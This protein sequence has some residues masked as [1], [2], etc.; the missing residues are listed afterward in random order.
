MCI[1]LE[2][3]KNAVEEIKKDNSWINDSHTKSEYDGVCSGLNR[4]IT[5]FER[6][7]DNSEKFTIDIYEYVDWD[8]ENQNKAYFNT[9]NFLD[10]AQEY[11]ENDNLDIE[12]ERI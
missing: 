11:L 7:S 2:E 4:I 1:T 9:S 12:I 5:H 6:L 10:T 8:D 3:L